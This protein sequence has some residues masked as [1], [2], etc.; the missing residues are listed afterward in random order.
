MFYNLNLDDKSYQEIE[1]DAVFQIP[2]ECPDWTNYNQS[3]PGIMLLGLLSWLKEIQQYHISQLCGWKR[4]KYLKLFGASLR[5]ARPARGILYHLTRQIKPDF[6]ALQKSI[7]SIKLHQKLL[8]ALFGLVFP[9]KLCQGDEIFPDGIA[10]YFIIRADIKG[11]LRQAFGAKC[12]IH[13]KI[14]AIPL[15]WVFSKRIQAHLLF[16]I[17][18]DIH[19][20]LQHFAG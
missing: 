8:P 16:Q 5:H 13:D 7:S 14:T 20:F 15:F 11:Y 1:A 12:L 18:A 4:Q 9:L 17:I 2:G 3:D 6:P 10:A 19:I